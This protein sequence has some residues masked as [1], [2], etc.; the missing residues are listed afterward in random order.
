[1]AGREDIGY[2]APPSYPTTTFWGP[3]KQKPTVRGMG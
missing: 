1:M 3:R 2:W